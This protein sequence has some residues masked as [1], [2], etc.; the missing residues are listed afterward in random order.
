MNPFFVTG[1]DTDAGKTY[2][3]VKLLEKAASEGKTTLGIKPIASG[4]ENDINDDA[5]K[6]KA[7]STVDLPLN[8]INPFR[9]INPIAPHIAAKQESKSLD[10]K[11]I[12]DAIQ[13]LLNQADFTIVEGAGGLMVPLNDQETLVDLIQTLDIPVILV[14]GM[15]LGCINH[16]LLT[17]QMIDQCGLR[18]AG[19]IANCLDKNMLVLEENIETL[20]LRMGAPRQIIQ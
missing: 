15:K 18:F 8:T 5:V 3:S 1:T 10:A 11:T 14:V 19:W 6:L 16:A 7:A 13:P 4:C 20:S 9:F 17:R 2:V 12:C